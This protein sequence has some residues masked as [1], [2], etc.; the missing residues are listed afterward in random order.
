MGSK[1]PL[2]IVTPAEWQKRTSL[3]FSKRSASTRRVDAAYADW[4]RATTS[5]QKTGVLMA[6]LDD[7]LKEK[8]NDW[9]K[10]DRDRESGGLMQYIYNLVVEGS[11]ARVIPSGMAKLQ[12]Y[13]IP[14][15]R[16]GVL[17]LLGNIDINMAYL[18][19]GLEGATVLGGAVASGFTTDTRHLDNATL[20]NKTVDIGKLKGISQGALASGA[21]V[22]LKIGTAATMSTGTKA[23][24]NTDFYINT[25]PPKARPTPGFPLTL[26]AFEMVKE[27]PALFVN[28]YV[29]P[30]TMVVGA[31]ALVIDGLNSLR[32]LIQNAIS[33]LFEWVKGKLLGDRAWAWD[34]SGAVVKGVIKLVVAKCLES[35]APLIGAAMDIGGGIMKTIRAAK[36]RI[37]VWLE[38]R[39]IVL[40]PG[41]PEQLANS[42]E[43]EMSKGIF[44]GLWTILKG[45]ASL[46]LQ[47]F[48]PGAGNLV[49]SIV[50]G[51]E[52]MVKF[53]W[54]IWEQSKIHKFLMEA[55][56]VFAEERKKAELVT[57]Y[58][59]KGVG[60][61]FEP[62]MDPSCGG[63]I[64]DL[65]RFKAFY[66]RGCDASP[67]IPM[68][69]LNSGIC[70]S[71]MTLIRMF[72]DNSQHDLISQATFDA[73][74]EY[75]ARLKQ[76]GRT[77]LNSAGFQF[78]SASGPVQGLLNHAVN[79]HNR[80]VSNP[81]KF[82][83]FLSA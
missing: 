28:P 19:V 59:G 16:Y 46:A 75:F 2:R 27:D 18:S 24:R 78:T 73:G 50:T 55:R 11:G 70:G 57:D 9:S 68:L 37:G 42:I 5:P 63:I 81:E 10:V 67:L 33:D 30:A 83:R 22:P 8:G 58:R 64:H 6:A 29:L 12:N 25:K 69:T 49:S 72:G 61:Q 39:K 41:H 43:S 77:Y 38:R 48:L 13:D 66:Q 21:S 60:L 3:T 32:I 36:D 53:L 62:N 14:H 80:D 47:S 74:N 1:G 7:Y 34:V 56:Q 65:P 15:S 45:V 4:Y 35:A 71:L 20:A 76:F 31:G 79:D 26:S 52:W 40:N 82:L 54:R 17:Y 51:I 44:S 23:P